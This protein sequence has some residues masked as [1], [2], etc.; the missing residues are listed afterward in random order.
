MN[1]LLIF[2]YLNTTT[3]Q[4]NA[5]NIVRQSEMLSL[6]IVMQIAAIMATDA[7]LTASKK[8]DNAFELRIFLTK[9]LSK[10]TKTNEGRKIAIVEIMAPASPLI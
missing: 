8:T 5:I 2:W 3:A 6:T 7:T 10:A 1:A 4:M 9:G